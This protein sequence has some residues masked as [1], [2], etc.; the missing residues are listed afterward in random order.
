MISMHQTQNAAPHGTEIKGGQVSR[1]QRAEPGWTRHRLPRQH[2][3]RRQSHKTQSHTRSMQGGSVHMLLMG[4][5][6]SRKKS[7]IG[8]VSFTVQYFGSLCTCA[9]VPPRHTPVLRWPGSKERWP[10]KSQKWGCEL[11]SR[12]PR[13]GGLPRISSVMPRICQNMAKFP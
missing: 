2:S 10:N 1:Q 5:R 6:C 4:M 3:M 11:R 7:S 13:S 8:C 12:T 9:H